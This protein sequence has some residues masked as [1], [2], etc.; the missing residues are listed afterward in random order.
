M[1]VVGGDSVVMLPLT[2][3][4]GRVDWLK[5]GHFANLAN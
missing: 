3:T 4:K 5:Y 2:I 1:I